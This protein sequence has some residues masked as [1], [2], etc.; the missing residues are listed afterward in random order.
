MLNSPGGLILVTGPSGAGKTTTLYACLHYLNNGSRKLNT[1]EDPIE[2]EISGVRQSQVET[3]IGL[4]FPDLLRS[5]L[6][7][8]PDVI[9]IGEV[10]DKVTA[11]TA[12]RAAN[13]GHLV[14]A[15]MHA[16]TT[17]GAV[18]A[19]LNY[20]VHPHFLASSLLGIVSQRLVRVLCG[21]CRQAIDVAGAPQMFDDVRQDLLPGQGQTIYGSKACDDC[22]Q[23]GFATRTGVF[24][25]MNASAKMRNLISNMA[26]ER[27]VFDEAVRHGMRDFRRSGLLKVAQGVTSME[28]LLRVIPA[29]Y[30]ETE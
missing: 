29:E 19:L 11:Q 26:G 12:I 4:D 9:L 6:R 25:V 15:S 17:T 22:R 14:L 28:E 23:T 18:Q 16:P 8:S 21:K 13:S 10:R 24:E 3:S 27:E 20:E 30:L 7:Q 2:S 1:I 5:V